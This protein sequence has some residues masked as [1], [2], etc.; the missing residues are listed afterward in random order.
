ME[1]KLHTGPQT[2][3]G[4]KVGNK[5]KKKASSRTFQMVLLLPPL[6]QRQL[7]HLLFLLRVLAT[8]NQR[9]RTNCN[10]FQTVK[11][12]L[13]IS[14]RGDFLSF[15]FTLSPSRKKRKQK[16][17]TSQWEWERSLS[18]AFHKLVTCSGYPCQAEEGIRGKLQRGG[19]KVGFIH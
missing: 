7:E 3:I 10:C 17:Q 4:F 6:S 19:R 16:E 14:K 13:K 15:F 18:F 1:C 9:L 11:I 8:T 12:A 5:N 2:T